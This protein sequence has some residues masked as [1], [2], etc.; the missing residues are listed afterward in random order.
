MQI[1]MCF[2][3]LLILFLKTDAVLDDLPE[4]IKVKFVGSHDIK[5]QLMYCLV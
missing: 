1:S 2:F 5:K 3:G 4:I